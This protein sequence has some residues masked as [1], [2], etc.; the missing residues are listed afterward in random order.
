MCISEKKTRRRLEF[1]F[2]KGKQD[3]I[4][5][6]IKEMLASL[7]RFSVIDY[8]L[9]KQWHNRVSSVMVSVLSFFVL[10]S[11]VDPWLNQAKEHK[12]GMC[13]M[14][15]HWVCRIMK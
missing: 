9:Y 5:Q 3:I 13:C 4:P 1:K 6:E 7:N 14:V 11:G 2:K 8:F 12:I 15:L 10:D